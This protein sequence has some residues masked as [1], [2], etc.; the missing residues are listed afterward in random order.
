M[1]AR[2]T[3]QVGGALTAVLEDHQRT[4]AQNRRCTLQRVKLPALEVHLDKAHA[5]PAI[6]EKAVKCSNR[7]VDHIDATCKVAWQVEALLQSAVAAAVSD[8]GKAGAPGGGADRGSFDIGIWK[9]P[10][11][12]CGRKM[13]NS[14]NRDYSARRT[15]NVAHG[16]GMNPDTRPAI[17]GEVARLEDGRIDRPDDVLEKIAELADVGGL[18]PR[19]PLRVIMRHSIIA[20]R[21]A[22]PYPPPGKENQRTEGWHHRS[23]RGRRW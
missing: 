8:Y 20:H 9:A 13:R 6:G 22:S 18:H 14:L 19:L 23:L 15:N 21:S 2:V 7:H 12:K 10:L 3:V 17:D 11:R 5:L 16:K 4:V 1:L